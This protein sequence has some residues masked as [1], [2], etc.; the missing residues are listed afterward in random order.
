MAVFM[1]TL[2]L[3]AVYLEAAMLSQTRADA[4]VFYDCVAL[5]W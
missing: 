4:L 1:P 2:L 3:A 5:L